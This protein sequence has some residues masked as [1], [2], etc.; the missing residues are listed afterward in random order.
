MQ[1]ADTLRFILDDRI[2]DVKVGPS[3]VPLGL[4]KQFQ[5]DVGE[6][7]AGSD[8][9]VD[10]L[11]AIVAVEEGSMAFAV[12]G[13]LVATKLWQD[14]SSLR[15]SENL[16]LV[17][18]KRAEVVERWQAA[19]L[20]Y[21]NRSYALATSLADVSIRIDRES[22]YRNQF[23]AAWVPV[24]KYLTGQITDLGGTSKANV[25]LRV[26][27]GQVLTIA[28]SQKLLA[29]EERNRLYKTATLRV[30]AEEQ[31]ETGELRNL[32]LQ[33]FEDTRHRWD[34]A[35]FEEMVRRGTAVWKDVPDDWLENL[36][37]GVG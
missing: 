27:S 23:R 21:P 28:S 9:E 13:L 18:P 30:S 20:K 31:L 26:A 24:E 36:R 10:P 16:A 37:S 19:A 5:Q 22:D 12:T 11:K 2:D 32:E 7:L 14:V 15:A 8:R 34:E 4:L 6:F 35:H 17:D 3:R 33:S 1:P 29:D 25:H